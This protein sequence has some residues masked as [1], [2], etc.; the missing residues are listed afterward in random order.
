MKKLMNILGLS[1]VSFLLISVIVFSIDVSRK[2]P[3]DG[4]IYDLFRYSVVTWT[5]IMSIWIM[6]TVY[7]ILKEDNL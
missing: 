1:A 2:I 5:V 3:G 4:L 6:T 7:K